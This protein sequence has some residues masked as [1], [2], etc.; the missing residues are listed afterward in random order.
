MLPTRFIIVLCYSTCP[1]RP[2]D[3]SDPVVA[4]RSAGVRTVLAPR[5]SYWQ[6]ADPWRGFSASLLRLASASFTPAHVG[7]TWMRSSDGGEADRECWANAEDAVLSLSYLQG[8]S[9]VPPRQP[10]CPTSGCERSSHRKAPRE[11][12]DS[13]AGRTHDCCKRATFFTNRPHH[14]SPLPGFACAVS[15]T[16][17]SSTTPIAKHSV[18]CGSSE[19][20]HLTSY[21]DRSQRSGRR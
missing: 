7:G 17:R 21:I 9:L 4:F 10:R 11:G 12:I 20:R 15:T 6:I 8:A 13:A 14:K 16:A 19:I 2:S 1:R 5:P 3:T 18:V